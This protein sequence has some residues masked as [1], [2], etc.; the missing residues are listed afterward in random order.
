LTSKELRQ[1][2][3]DIKT[4][5]FPHSFRHRGATWAVNECWPDAKIQ[6]HDRWKS[7]SC[8]KYIRPS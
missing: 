8:K 5:L 4:K 3:D 7:E 1:I 6:A 2:Y